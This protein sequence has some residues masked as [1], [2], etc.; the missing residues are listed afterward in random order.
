M[1]MNK[2][3]KSLCG[4]I[5]AAIAGGAVLSTNGAEVRVGLSA[6]ETYVGAPVTLRIQVAD[7]TKAELPV[8]PTIDGVEV[9]AVGMPSR[10]TQITT[11]NGRTTT[12]VTQ[13][14]VYQLTPQRA[15]TFQIPSVTI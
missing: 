5:V 8:V 12:S 3:M 10:S 6:R 11:I 14:Y 1:T 2:K 7:A 13:T 15:G 4:L 9:K